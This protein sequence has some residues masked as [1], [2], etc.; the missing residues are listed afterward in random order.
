MLRMV[1]ADDFAY[2][3]G[4]LA[5]SCLMRCG[6]INLHRLIRSEVAT[7]LLKGCV[8]LQGDLR[9]LFEVAALLLQHA[10]A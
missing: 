6:F 7:R 9:C 4:L 2:A 3:V 10:V 1:E 8:G 5:T